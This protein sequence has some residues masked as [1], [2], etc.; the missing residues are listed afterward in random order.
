MRSAGVEVDHNPFYR[1][2][3]VFLYKCD[4]VHRGVEVGGL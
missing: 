3:C 2:G 4:A 1:N